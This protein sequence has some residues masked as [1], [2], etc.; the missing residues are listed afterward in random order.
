MTQTNLQCAATHLA[1]RGPSEQRCV[2]GRR[3]V[4][5]GTPHRDGLGNDWVEAE[6][7]VTG[8]LAS[9]MAESGQRELV[10]K[11]YEA[12]TRTR[13]QQDW[14]DDTPRAAGFAEGYD[15]GIHD[16]LSVIQDKA[17]ELGVTLS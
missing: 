14:E 5:R 12:V 10:A 11:L 6:S 13:D 2:R 17:R 4:G 16:A 7:T 15:V 3:H 9:A 1:G 8:A